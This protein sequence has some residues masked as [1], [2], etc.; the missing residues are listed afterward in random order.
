VCLNLSG[1]KFVQGQHLRNLGHNATRDAVRR[2]NM[3]GLAL[4]AGLEVNY[5][6]DWGPLGLAEASLPF[7]NLHQVEV[8]FVSKLIHG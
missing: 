5:W 4:K 1:L 7:E 6:M 8:A 3:W 2:F